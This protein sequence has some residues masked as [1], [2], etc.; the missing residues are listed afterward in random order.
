[1]QEVFIYINNNVFNTLLAL[2]EEEQTRG[3]MYEQWPPPAMVFIYKNSSINKFWMKNTPSP[4]D[5]LFCDNNKI[6]QI[7]AG[8]PYSTDIIGKD[9]P[10]NLV[11]ELPYGTVSQ[12]KIKLGDQ[13]GLV[14]PT[15]DELKKI[16]YKKPW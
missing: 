9:I 2:S 6:N 4:L 11:I 5:I 1:M 3:L 10:S 13:V 15:L 16:I 12:S 8:T 14:K 7:C